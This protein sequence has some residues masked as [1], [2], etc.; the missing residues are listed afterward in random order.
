MK[1]T[2]PL[3]YQERM[4]KAEDEAAAAS[5]EALGQICDSDARSRVMTS[6][7]RSSEQAAFHR[8]LARRL[9]AIGFR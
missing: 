1:G 7:R 2:P 3:D 5:L 9:R 4:A 6:A 8:W